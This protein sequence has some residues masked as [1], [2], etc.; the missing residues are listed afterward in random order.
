MVTCGPL[1]AH[2]LAE[3]SGSFGRLWRCLLCLTCNGLLLGLQV[4][5]KPL[6]LPP[7][8]GNLSVP[9]KHQHGETQRPEHSVLR[10]Q[11]R[12]AWHQVLLLMI[13]IPLRYTMLYYH[14]V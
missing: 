7:K 13:E 5:L 8:N 11:T 2:Y 1:S 4:Q 12:A 9:A 14:N 10:A 6:V 3:A